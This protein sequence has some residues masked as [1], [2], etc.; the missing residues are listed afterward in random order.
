MNISESLRTGI[1]VTLTEAL[2]FGGMTTV[3]GL[4]IVFGVLLVLMIV[5]YLFKVIFYKSPD[6]VKKDAVTETV[7]ENAE[8]EEELVAVLTAAAA[9]C[10]KTSANKVRIN[11]YK[12]V[13]TDPP[14]W[15]RAARRESIE[16]KL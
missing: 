1:G 14:V 6:K 4:A 2:G 7:S 8:D 9:A 11:T 3:V 16:N 13:H 12:R 5:L 15:N 10:M